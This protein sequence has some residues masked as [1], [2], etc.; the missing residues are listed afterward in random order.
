MSMPLSTTTPGSDPILATDLAPKATLEACRNTLAE[1]PHRAN[2]LRMTQAE[3]GATGVTG[4]RSQIRLSFTILRFYQENPQLLPLFE[5]AQPGRHRYLTGARL[6]AA[7]GRQ[8]VSR[9]QAGLGATELLLRGRLTEDN[10]RIEDC[11]TALWS[12]PATPPERRTVLE[13]RFKDP[14]RLRQLFQESLEQK[15]TRRDERKLLRAAAR[16]E[17]DRLRQAPK[18]AAQLRRLDPTR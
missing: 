11:Y 14:M 5:T 8:V 13:T 4:T 16:N 7:Q 3:R 9:L 6:F 15:K 18:D 12:D 1:A 2:L 10:D 17:A